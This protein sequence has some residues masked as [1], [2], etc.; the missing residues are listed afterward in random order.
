MRTRL[1]RKVPARSLE[2]LL[3]DGGVGCSLRWPGDNQG[4]TQGGV[5]RVPNLPAWAQ[6][7]PFP[8][9]FSCC[10][11]W[12]VARSWQDGQEVTGMWGHLADAGPCHPLRHPRDVTWVRD[13]VSPAL[14]GLGWGSRT[15]DC[16]RGLPGCVRPWHPW[17]EVW[18]QISSPRTLWGHSWGGMCPPGAGGRPQLWPCSQVPLGNTTLGFFSMF[19]C[20]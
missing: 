10:P 17:V 20:S 11:S 19:F 4:T 6:L 12:G 14:G 2:A 16:P 15:W 3:E 18:V 7:S 8:F 1:Q 9:S 5:T 13:V